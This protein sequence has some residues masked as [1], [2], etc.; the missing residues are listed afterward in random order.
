MSNSYNVASQIK[1]KKL[2][3][4]SY[5]L[6]IIHA[7]LIEIDLRVGKVMVLLAYPLYIMG[8]HSMH[9]TVHIVWH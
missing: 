7:R 8:Q 4:S 2:K 6:L 9:M 3:T 5:E 1:S